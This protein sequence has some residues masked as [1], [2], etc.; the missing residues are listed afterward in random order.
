[1]NTYQDPS[2]YLKR[3]HQHANYQDDDEEED[4]ESQ[5]FRY[6][7]QRLVY[8]ETSNNHVLEF[9]KLL[10]N[11]VSTMESEHIYRIHLYKQMM[12]LENK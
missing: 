6:I 12:D 11:Q 3:L 4:Y 2:F 1:M 8:N 7:K 9:L 5:E 10:N